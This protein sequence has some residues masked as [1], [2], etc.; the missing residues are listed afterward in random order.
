M[1]ID[2]LLAWATLVHHPALYLGECPSE[3]AF[4]LYS[5]SSGDIPTTVAIDHSSVI[6]Y[7]VGRM[8]DSASIG[9]TFCN[10][11]EPPLI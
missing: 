3:S 8:D 6:I 5:A 2:H 7:R 1:G 11:G 4:V 9:D 10:R